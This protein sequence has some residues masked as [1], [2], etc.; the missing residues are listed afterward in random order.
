MEHLVLVLV[1]DEERIAS[2]ARLRD[3]GFH[4]KTASSTDEAVAQ[5]SVPHGPFSAVVVVRESDTSFADAARRI[6]QFDPTLPIIESNGLEP[7][8]AIVDRVVAAVRS[9]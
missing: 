9:G 4:I 6:T 8:G 3:A 2:F 1:D 7:V 5:L